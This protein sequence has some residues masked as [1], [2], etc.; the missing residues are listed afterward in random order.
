MLVLLDTDICIHLINRRAGFE[1][2]LRRLSG[3]SIGEICISAIAVSELRFGVAKSA[4]SSAN[5]IALEEF[6]SRF[7]LLDYPVEAS[8]NY[9]KIR[10]ELERAGT[11]IG[12]N[13]LLIA[14]HA[15][16]IKASIVTAN[17]SEF[18][19]IK[20]LKVLDWLS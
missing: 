8:T 18:Q 4:R 17:I 10:T 12:N 9:G 19:R 5:A 14:S 7:E 13:D 16:A 15:L 3:R 11:P 6:L 20:G 1:R 2:V